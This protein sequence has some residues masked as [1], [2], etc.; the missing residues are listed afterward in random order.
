MEIDRNNQVW[1]GIE[2]G[3]TK[4]VCGLADASG[5]LLDEVRF[6]TTNPEQTLARAIEYFRPYSETG[7]LVAVGIGSF[8]PIDPN[9]DSPT[10]GF[11]TST[12]KPG[13]QQTDFAGAIARALDTPVAFDTDTNAAGEGEHRWGAARDLDTFLY[14]TVGTGIGGGGMARGRRLRGLVHPEM[15]HVIVPRVAGDDFPGICPFHGDCLEGMVSGPALKARVG[16]SAEE[17]AGD[18]PLWQ[19]VAHY[20][21]AAI[22]NYVYV[23]S[24]QRIILGG[25]VMRRQE[26]FALIRERVGQWL[27]GYVQSD[28]VLNRLDDYIVP[29]ALGERAGVLGAVAL[30]LG[31]GTELR[32]S[33]NIRP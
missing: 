27:G 1:G 14:L 22:A 24:P 31:A 17:V 13:W 2:A 25:G 5:R 30:A 18:D 29:P 10:Y 3:G 33:R 9:P 19:I 26:L 7:R 8:G 15:G 32:Q 12:P 28:L 4:F 16:R 6:P 20:L 21:S 23:L 11:I